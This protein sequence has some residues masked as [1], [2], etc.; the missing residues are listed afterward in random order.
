MYHKGSQGAH[1]YL[2]G[3]KTQVWVDFS[4]FT[5]GFRNSIP[6]KPSTMKGKV[7]VSHLCLTLCNP[8]P[9]CP[10]NSPDKNTGV[11]SCSLSRGSSQP[12]DRTPTVKADSLLTEPPGKLSTIYD[13]NRY[14]KV[15]KGS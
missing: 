1:I 5:M 7:K 3:G 9:N 13:K 8:V 12:R 2:T 14:F 6:S 11:Y 15:C 10:W 4:I